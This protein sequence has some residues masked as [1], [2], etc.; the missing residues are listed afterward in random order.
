M[1]KGSWDTL[2]SNAEDDTDAA[3][4]LLG[5]LAAAKRSRLFDQAS[6]PASGLAS[7]SK[8]TFSGPRWQRSARYADFITSTSHVYITHMKIHN[9]V[10]IY[11]Q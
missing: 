11:G 8:T 9:I 7:N 4:Q 6:D 2:L 1:V 5:E 10:Y 3:N